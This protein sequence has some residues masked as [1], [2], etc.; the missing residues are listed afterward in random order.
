MTL[1]PSR[2][3][4]PAVRA[5]REV[6]RVLVRAGVRGFAAA[7]EQALDARRARRVPAR[8]HLV[9]MAPLLESR[10]TNCDIELRVA[11]PASEKIDPTRP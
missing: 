4:A 11:S 1:L 3:G 9:S 2:S 6:R 10:L 5:G 8:P 7:L